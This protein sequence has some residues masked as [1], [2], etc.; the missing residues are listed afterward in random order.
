M[1]T[2]ASPRIELQAAV[3]RAGSLQSPVRLDE[4]QGRC[5]RASILP[6]PAGEWMVAWD[7]ERGGNYDIW[8]YRSSGARERMTDSELW[9]TTPALARATDGRIWLAWERKGDHRRALRVS[10][11]QH[12][13]QDLGW[14][15]LAAGALA[16]PGK[17]ARTADPAFPLLGDGGDLRRAVSEAARA[18]QWRRCGCS[19]SAADGTPSTFLRGARVEARAVGGAANPVLQFDAG[20]G[21]RAAERAQGRGS[22]HR[23]RAEHPLPGTPIYDQMSLALD[24]ASGWLSMAYE[25]PKRRHTLDRMEARLTRSSGRLDTAADVSTFIAW[26]WTSTSSGLAVASGGR[27]ESD[28]AARDAALSAGH[29]AVSRS[30]RPGSTGW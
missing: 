3:W 21:L 12:L 19:G 10:R 29:A 13:R 9:D 4:G 1:K 15:G 2:P 22:A 17:R 20:I 5:H 24:D 11:S 7:E 23:R 27:P 8:T 18:R 6:L 25:V 26:I 16:F 14:I 30:G 28:R